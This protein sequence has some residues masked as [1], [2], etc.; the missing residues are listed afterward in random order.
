M[1]RNIIIL[2]LLLSAAAVHDN[3]AHAAEN[4]KPILRLDTGGHT[5][6]INKFAVTSDKKYLISCSDDKTIRVWDM[7][8]KKE[9]RKG[10]NLKCYFSYPVSFSQ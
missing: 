3:T 4:L 2:C 10:C 5:S 9:V 1:T 8:T 6:K 7:Q